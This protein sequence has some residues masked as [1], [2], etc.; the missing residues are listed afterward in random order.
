MKTILL[1]ILISTQYTS[2]G[3]VSKQ[4]VLSDIQSALAEKWSIVQIEAQGKLQDV[5]LK[6]GKAGPYIWLKSGGEAEVNFFTKGNGKWKCDVPAKTLTLIEPQQ[7]SVFLIKA[8]STTKMILKPLGKTGDMDP[9]LFVL[10]TI[11]KNH[12]D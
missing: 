11:V 7:E 1:V 12:T 5:K 3:Q 6:P 10:K 4:D 9:T 8:L 2:F